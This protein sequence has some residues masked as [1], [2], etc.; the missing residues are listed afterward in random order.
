MDG[1]TPVR[2]KPPSK[3]SESGWAIPIVLLLI[4]VY[5]SATSGYS[6]LNRSGFCFKRMGWVSD[7]E[8]LA[9]AIAEKLKPSYP[10]PRRMQVAKA[11][12]LRNPACCK[13]YRPDELVGQFREIENGD[14]PRPSYVSVDPHASFVADGNQYSGPGN[15]IVSSCADELWPWDNVPLPPGTNPP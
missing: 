12:L 1:D 9:F 14:V 11:F 2:P 7:E 5:L 10:A 3:S 8:K 13:V 6:A 4:A 15:V